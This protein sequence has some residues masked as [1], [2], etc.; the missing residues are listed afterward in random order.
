VAVGVVA[1]STLVTIGVGVYGLRQVQHGLE[2]VVNV[3]TEKSDLVAQMR[4]DIVAVPM[5]CATWRCAPRST[6]WRPTA[7]A[8]SN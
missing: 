8:S 7:R 2:Q 1:L 6:P 5:R 3:S 4:L